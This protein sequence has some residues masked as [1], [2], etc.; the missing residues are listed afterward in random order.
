MQGF[1]GVDYY[2]LD[3]LLTEEQKSIRRTVRA[4]V[5]EKVMP[6]IAECYEKHRFPDELIPEMGELG[7]FGANLTGYGSAGVD[8]ISYG[9]MMQELER[10]DSGLRSMASVQGALVMYPIYTFGSKEQKEKYLPDMARGEIIGCF[11]LTEPEHGSDP[12][13]M[14]TT[15]V[16]DRNHYILNGNKTWITNADVCHVAIVWAKVGDEVRGFL[17]ER[18]TPGFSTA[19]IEEKFSMRA[20]HTGEIYLNDCRIPKE[21]MLPEAEGLKAPLMCLNQARYGI[22]W[23]VIGA[24]M[25]CYEEALNYCLERSQFG[26]PIAS[27]QLVQEKLVDM[28][29]EITKAQLL[30]LRLGQLKEQGRVKHT[31]VSLAK[32]NNCRM[33]LDVARKARD[34]LGGN[35]ITLDYQAIRHMTNLETVFTY[36]GTDHIHT[37][38]LGQDLTG[39]QAFR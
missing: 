32:R 2:G 1:K 29:T 15:A 34:L 19:T 38:V 7:F 30:C 24:A 8:N 5:D 23:G 37:L 26:K 36:E 11:G 13:G 4:F 31:H 18:D 28:V 6:I 35:G 22:S 3:E 12:G 25:A 20:S 39:I 10:G 16:K 9:L 21:N 14:E 33:A 17:V 27:Y